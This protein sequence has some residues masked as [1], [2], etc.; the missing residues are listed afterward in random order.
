MRY[1]AILLRGLMLVA[2]AALV[3]GCNNSSDVQPRTFEMSVSNLTTAQPLSPVAVI[4]HGAGYHAFNI[5]APASTALEQLAEGGDNSALL[6]SLANDDAVFV[7][8]SAAT[9]IVPGGSETF[10]VSYNTTEPHLTLAAMLVNS[11]D[12][13]AA[14]D[15]IDLAAMAVGQQAVYYG[16]AFDAGTEA[17][18]ET[19]A[20]LPG[21]GGEGF[22]VDRDDRD[23]VAVHAGII[24]QDDGLPGSSLSAAH[25]FDNPVIK[26]RIKRLQ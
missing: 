25:R 2:V 1:S 7:R 13:F 12:G 17:N 10:L 14:L 22:N 11:N 26:V 9:A 16:H 6:A 18:S 23:W 8:M 3:Q 24:S 4:L 5:G 20:T 21:Q 15:S 19:A